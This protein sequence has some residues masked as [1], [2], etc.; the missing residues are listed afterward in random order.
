M[1]FF[2][3]SD[4]V[5]K[6][7]TVVGG[8]T[9]HSTYSPSATPIYQTTDAAALNRP[10]SSRT[11]VSTP[12]ANQLSSSSS[13]SSASS[14][15]S[16]LVTLA[17]VASCLTPE[18]FNKSPVGKKSKSF[19]PPSSSSPPGCL[20]KTTD[21]ELETKRK[22]HRKRTHGS[23]KSNGGNC[24]EKVQK[25]EPTQITDVS[26]ARNLSTN[27]NNQQTFS[28]D[29]PTDNSYSVR[30]LNNFLN[31]NDAGKETNNNNVPT[32]TNCNFKLDQNLLNASAIALAALHSQWMAATVESRIECASKTAPVNS[33]QTEENKSN[34]KLSETV[35]MEPS[36]FNNVIKPKRSYRR[37]KEKEFAR[38]PPSLDNE[39][40]GATSIASG[41]LD[42]FDDTVKF[43][44]NW[45]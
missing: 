42:Q 17:E 23:S 45:Q 14:P 35:K 2:G 7:P 3:R 38:A 26:A 15:H 16:N 32:T 40:S 37:R 27:N 18:I 19:S 22:N 34:I 44:L 33:S 12:F 21:A 4:F 11:Y 30:C 43:C 8:L 6:Q 39:H 31:N 9:A 41:S 13:P 36:S 29:P 5:T 20:K 10:S 24:E 28:S 25:L 1:H